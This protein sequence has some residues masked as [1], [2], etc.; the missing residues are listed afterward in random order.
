VATIPL[1]FQAIHP[2]DPYS[3]ADLDGYAPIDLRGLQHAALS[4]DGRRLAAVTRPG[5][6]DAEPGVLHLIDVAAWTDT[7]TAVRLEKSVAGLQFSAAGD[8]FFWVRESRLYRYDIARQA[9][10]AVAQLPSGFVPGS[11]RMLRD[12]RHMAMYG[13]AFNL[14]GQREDVPRVLI[15]DLDNGRVS[16]DIRIPDLADGPTSEQ[17]GTGP[18]QFREYHAGLAWDLPR[19]RLFLVDAASD[20]V[21]L[22]DLA[23]ATIV[24]QSAIRAKASWLDR[25]RA[26]LVTEAEAKWSAGVDRQVAVSPDGERL[27][28]TGLRR[29]IRSQSGGGTV[30][31]EVPMGLQV[32][33]TRDFAQLARLDLQV[34]DLALAPDGR[35]LLLS[36]AWMEWPSGTE[37]KQRG[38][39]LHILDADRMTKLAQLSAGTASAFHGFSRDARYA[40]VSHVGPASSGFKTM[41]SALDLRELRQGPERSLDG[42][43]GNLVAAITRS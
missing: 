10:D 28:I 37:G 9:L 5:S 40:Y 27:F 2:L 13:R 23:H 8:F 20:R 6:G 3:L 38:A 43:W 31:R 1:T 36:G 41:F 21:T 29:E 42:Y 16:G 33:A 25:L 14:Q 18:R 35:R 32:V 7:V 39:G 30:L 24:R 34:T 22:V 15:V 4:P 11:P 17:T 19:D 26:R 12:S